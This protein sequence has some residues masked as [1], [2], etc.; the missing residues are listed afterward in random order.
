MQKSLQ[1]EPCCLCEGGGDA[2]PG[3]QNF[4]KIITYLNVENKDKMTVEMILEQA[5]SYGLRAEVRATAIA[6][7]KDNPKLNAG[8]A[9]TQAAYEWDVL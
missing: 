9:Y 4:L 3:S 7:I 1:R 6:F 5:Q 8:S 2:S